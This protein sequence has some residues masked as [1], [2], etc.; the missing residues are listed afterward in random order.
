MAYHVSVAAFDGPMDLLLHLVTKA[1]V[2]IRDIFISQITD[3]FLEYIADLSELDMDRASEFLEMAARLVE[4][5]SRRLLPNPEE[6][7]E[8]AAQ[9]E[10]ILRRLEE[11][12]QFKMASLELKRREEE[13]GQQYFR[14]PEEILEGEIR[15]EDTSV[16]LLLKAFVEIMRKAQEQED[17]E[18]EEDSIQRE[19]FTVA[20]QMLRV[21]RLLLHDSRLTF[22]DILSSKPSREEVVTTFLAVLELILREGLCVAQEELFG[23]IVLTPRAKGAQEEH[24]A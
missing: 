16:E 23:D 18:E 7:E 9:E 8:L 24:G 11:Y 6:D 2:D 17:D 21:Q 22:Y 12:R 13:A 20:E 1:Q 3:Q 10:D 14:L 4:I 15:V 5:K 19:S